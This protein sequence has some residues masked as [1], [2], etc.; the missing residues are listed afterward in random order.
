MTQTKILE[1]QRLNSTCS[2]GSSHVPAALLLRWSL[3]PGTWHTSLCH[4]KFS[5]VLSGIHITVFGNI[6]LKER[7]IEMFIVPIEYLTIEEDGSKQTQPSSSQCFKSIH[8]FNP[9]PTT[10]VNIFIY[11]HVEKLI[12]TGQDISLDVTRGSWRWGERKGGLTHS[13]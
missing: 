11:V 5:C 4:Q 8:Y 1:M 2:D 9:L 3:S 6:I 7:E 13:N 10:R 12:P